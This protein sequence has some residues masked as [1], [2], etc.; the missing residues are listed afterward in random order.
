MTPASRFDEL[1]ATFAQTRTEWQQF[2]DEGHKVCAQVAHG[3]THFLGVPEGLW[4]VLP[5]DVTP[6]AMH[7]PY[8]IASAAKLT[9]DGH[10]M[11][12]LQITLVPPGGQGPQQ[13]LLLPVKV[14]KQKADGNRY[15]ICIAD[16]MCQTV[17][18]GLPSECQALFE[19]AYQLVREQLDHQV[20]NFLDDAKTLTPRKIGFY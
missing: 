6:E 9:P 8:D 1:C 15:E 2:R 7:L 12:L 4:R 10:W 11:L 18:P 14:A 19:D 16:K 3:F 17:N 13:P 20:E 5:P